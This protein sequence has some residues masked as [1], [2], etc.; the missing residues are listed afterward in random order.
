[1]RCSADGSWTSFEYWLSVGSYG[2]IHGA[3]IASRTGMTSRMRAA[4]VR[5]DQR[6]NRTTPLKTRACNAALWGVVAGVIVAVLIYPSE[7][8]AS[9]CYSP[10]RIRGSNHE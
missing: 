1:M 3:R 7:A 5:G 4:V 10:Y 8:P 6:A 2:A 9:A